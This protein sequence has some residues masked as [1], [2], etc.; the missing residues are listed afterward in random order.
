[1]H[2]ERQKER[3][4]DSEIQCETVRDRQRDRKRQRER[5][6]ERNRKTLRD[7]DAHSETDG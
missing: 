5:Q 2:R 4:R 1:M 3:L 6:T 7:R